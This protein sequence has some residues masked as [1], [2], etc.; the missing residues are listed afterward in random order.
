MVLIRAAF[1]IVS[2]VSPTEFIST[3]F[4]YDLVKMVFF[5][6]LIGSELMSCIVILVSFAL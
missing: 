6:C 2:K 4:Y 3:R 5:N 1:L